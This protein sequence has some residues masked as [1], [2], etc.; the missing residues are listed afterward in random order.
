MSA[1]KL[2]LTNPIFH[3]DDAARAHLE[4]QRWPDGPECPHCGE[5]NITKLE[6]KAHRPGLYQCNQ[7]R[8]Q[9][10]VTVGTVFE[11]SKIGL[12]KWVLVT[13]L[14]S[15]S[16][17]GISAKQIERMIGVSY[18]TA[19]FMCHRIRLAM[20]PVVGVDNSGPIGGEGKTIEADETYV[21]GKARNVHI[22][23]PIPEKRPV[24]ALVERGG[25]V[26]AKHVADV[27]AKTVREVIVTQAS[28][29]SELNTDE[30]LIYYWLGREFAKHMAVNHSASEY[31]GKDGKTTTNSVESFFAIVKRQMYGTHHAVS[32]AHL[33]RYINEIAFKWN[34]RS[35]LG[36]EDSERANN[37]L[38]G[39]SGKRLTYRRT[40]KAAIG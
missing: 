2:D 13:H 4:A 40:D 30:S 17:K 9:F 3:S 22:G 15:A 12:A 19:W 18:K 28:R 5:R 33:Q 6:G 38:K 23:K 35:A 29:K 16:K 39:A 26:R 31:V 1:G 25:E 11:D 21:G 7:C 27:T 32:E 37:A 36:I 20:T 34:N 8:Q 14:M 10:S 24:V